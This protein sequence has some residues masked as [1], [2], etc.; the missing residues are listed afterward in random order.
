MTTPFFNTLPEE[1]KKAFLALSTVSGTTDIDDSAGTESTPFV[2]LTVAAP[3]ECDLHD[4]EVWLDLA[5]ATTGFAAVETSVTLQFAAARAVDGTN[6]RREA[7]QEAALSGTNAASRMAKL[8]IGR[9]PAG[10]SVK[11]YAV[12]SADVTS[13]MEIPYQVV[14]RGLYAPTVTAIAA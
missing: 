12:A 5:K 13:D 2:L 3:A 8:T 14:Y 1:F 11:I 6:Y 9:I 7:Y 10:Q 4:V